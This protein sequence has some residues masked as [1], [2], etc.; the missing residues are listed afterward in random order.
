MTSAGFPALIAATACSNV[1]P[2]LTPKTSTNP[3][4]AASK[5][6]AVPPVVSTG[7]QPQQPL[8]AQAPP[9]TTTQP[10]QGGGP[11]PA[12]LIAGLGV[13][14]LGAGYLVGRAQRSK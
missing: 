11:P 2:N 6:S 8:A 9:T 10:A 13:L 12:A 4:A 7:Q 14:L 3:A 1:A 5:P